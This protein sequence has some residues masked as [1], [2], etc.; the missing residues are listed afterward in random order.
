[1]KKSLLFFLLILILV[2]ASWAD[3]YNG[4]TYGQVRERDNTVR[5]Q[6]VPCWYLSPGNYYTYN[7][8]Y[9][10]S[11]S[12]LS[13]LNTG[14][15]MATYRYPVSRFGQVWGRDYNGNRRLEMY[16]QDRYGRTNYTTVITAHHNMYRS[17]RY[18]W[19]RCWNRK[20]WDNK[21][22][23]L[24]CQTKPDLKNAYAYLGQGLFV[25]GEAS[26]GRGYSGILANLGVTTHELTHAV[27]GSY[28]TRLQYS[29][30]AAAV[31]EGC[32]DIMA[33]GAMYLYGERDYWNLFPVR[34]LKSARYYYAHYKKNPECHLGGHVLGHAAYLMSTKIGVYRVTTATYYAMYVYIRS[35]DSIR[36][37]YW[38]ILNSI[39]RLYGYSAYRA[40]YYASWQPI[41]K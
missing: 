4:W 7:Y 41:Y 33:V 27:L 12:W 25:F 19:Y 1:M 9:S 34:D 10:S 21:G 23:R 20:S 17:L 28:P 40:A 6:W 11:G 5:W 30:E 26:F 36:T 32:S 37:A 8:K 29:G 16:D 2:P 3:S 13:H 39:Y 35:N 22:T 15:Y 24:I 38:K 31:H 14:Q 18:Y